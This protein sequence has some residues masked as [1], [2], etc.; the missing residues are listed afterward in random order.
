[1][2]AQLRGEVVVADSTGVV[3]DVGGVGFRVSCPPSV[4]AAPHAQLTLATSLVVREDSLS[5]YGFSSSSERDA[6]ELLLSASGVG[7][8]TALACI[9][10]L[11]LPELVRAIRSENLA[12]LTRVPGI[13]RKGAQ[14]LVIELKDKILALGN[15]ADLDGSGTVSPP[16]WREQVLGGL[17]GLGW[18]LKDAEAACDAVAPLVAENPAIPVGQIMRAALQ[19]LAR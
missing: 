4:N 8:R 9:S 5:L 1:V 14:K 11:P 7:P 15:G 3:L 18:S 10:V 12:A 2:I 6:F 16:D 19:S 13:G 17:Q